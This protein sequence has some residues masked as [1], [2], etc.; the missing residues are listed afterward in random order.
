MSSLK[1]IFK[2]EIRRVSAPLIMT[3]A[4]LIRVVKELFPTIHEAQSLKLTYQDDE[5]DVVALNS[6]EEL[7]EALN[8]MERQNLKVF[9]FTIIAE[10]IPSLC[11]PN[12]TSIHRGI[13][14][15]S[16]GVGPIV[17]IRYKCTVRDDYD[18]CS[19]CESKQEQDYPML[20]IYK[21]TFLPRKG[22][23]SVEHRTIRLESDST[24]R[25]HHPQVHYHVKCDGCGA[26]PIIGNRFQC[27]KRPN[28]DL[29]ES[30]KLND[31]S[32]YVMRKIELPACLGRATFSKRSSKRCGF[33]PRPPVHRHVQCD[34]C[35]MFPL[36]G[37]RYRCTVRPNYDLCESCNEEEA[38]KYP[39]TPIEAPR[40]G[41]GP[42]RGG[43]N[44]SA[45]AAGLKECAPRQD[46]VSSSETPDMCIAFEK[47]SSAAIASVSGDVA[48]LAS[49]VAS[50]SAEPSTSVVAAAS[51]PTTANLPSVHATAPAASSPTEPVTVPDAVASDSTPDSARVIG[52]DE[53]VGC[54]GAPTAPPA[55]C[56]GST[57]GS[58]ELESL[59]KQLME[60][61]LKE[62][63]D[64]HSPHDDVDRSLQHDDFSGGSLTPSD[65]YEAFHMLRMEEIAHACSD[66]EHEEEQRAVAAAL[67]THEVETDSA[68]D[69]DPVASSDLVPA[70]DPSSTDDNCEKW[71]KELALL[72]EMG[73]VERDTVID[74]LESIAGDAERTEDGDLPSEVLVRVISSLMGVVNL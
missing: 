67:V 21:P 27:T 65:G 46:A 32:G 48:I 41:F 13:T 69:G 24:R 72:A 43:R 4:A 12:S 22:A 47:G 61:A 66:D 52:N 57:D 5:G 6:D 37:M 3:M 59:E 53:V 2:S 15:D 30:C 56:T 68:A 35:G 8:V 62:S 31:S 70:C 50:S 71:E 63:V 7:S 42:C 14:C 36:V 9:R 33:D 28:Y 29:C 58:E 18:L 25:D 64:F 74:C 39:M 51:T 20:K 73:F 16:C 38:G 17:G 49:A 23:Y 60:A 40:T 26:L 1:F 19:A 54:V 10:E 11:G 55:E 34:G 44:W 45:A